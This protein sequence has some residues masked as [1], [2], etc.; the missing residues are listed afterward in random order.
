MR[1]RLV[2]FDIFLGMNGSGKSYQMAKCRRFNERNLILPATRADKVWKG[3]PELK[4]VVGFKADPMDPAGRRRVP[5]V[6]YPE[7]NSFKGD[8]VIFLEGSDRDR[9][10]AF[11]SIIH[12]EWGFH[13]GGFFMDDSKRYIH[14][15]G[16]LPHNVREFFGNRRQNAVDIFLAGWQFQDINSDFWGF[17][18]MQLWIGNVQRQPTSMLLE[19]HPNPN[20]VIAAYLFSQAINGK[21]PTSQRWHFEPYPNPPL[22]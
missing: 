1:E 10:L 4:A 15:K 2:R 12:P 6:Y 11:N 13:R 18:G 22:R 5:V 9:A 3:I 21:L 19:N 14:T 17:G 7:I 16:S 20:G 8:R